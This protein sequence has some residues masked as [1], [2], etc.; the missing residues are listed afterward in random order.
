M[1]AVSRPVDVLMLGTF[2]VWKRGTL[3]ARA[4]PL[5]KELV[6]RGL[7]VALVTTPWDTP[8]QRGVIE[9]A[10]G[11]TIVNTTSVSPSFPLFAIREQVAWVDHFQPKLV[12]LFKPK[13]FGGFA[14]LLVGGRYPLVV[15]H[16]DWEGRG[17]WNEV[18]DYGLFQRWAFA[19]QE[20]ALLRRADAVTA[21]STTLALQASRL[22][23]GTNGDDERSGTV[24][25]L[26]NGLE[27]AWMRVLLDA[28]STGARTEVTPVDVVVYSRFA[29]FPE[30]WLPEFL[31][32]LDRQTLVPRSVRV[33]GELPKS[34]RLERSY[35]NLVVESMGYV[36]KNR[37]PDLLASA[38]LAV[39]PYHDSLVTRSKQS[40][41][42]LELMA[43][44]VPVIASQVGDVA[45]TLGGGGIV[46]PG[47]APEQFAQTALDLLGSP[48][49]RRDLSATARNRVSTHYTFSSL[50]PALLRTYREHAG[51]RL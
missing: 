38:S 35:P 14:A 5:A 11:L 28:P 50:T 51:V 19:W 41:K 17:G 22:R 34:V 9:S 42:L 12:H 7:S 24:T 26:P 48:E 3:Q 25:L 45:R 40:I 33:I 29:E 10:G 36:A 39:Y 4:L 20:P 30:S 46:L 37:L 1:K 2:G 47:S 44:G 8:G 13:G 31:K 21:A 15:D 32:A 6:R 18:G 49:R 16:D 23:T 27:D 43:A